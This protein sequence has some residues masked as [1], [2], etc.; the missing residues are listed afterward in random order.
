MNSIFLQLPEDIQLSILQGAEN[1]LGLRAAIIEKD[2]WVCWLLQQI[3]SL[4]EAMAFKGGTSLSKVF[5]LI[6]RFSEDIDI[7]IDYRNFIDTIDFEHSSKNQFKQLGKKLKDAMFRYVKQTILP[8]LKLRISEAF[9]NK[10]FKIELDDEAENLRFYYPSLLNQHEHY[11][12]EHV[13]IEFGARN[14]THPNAKHEITTLLAKAVDKLELPVTEVTTLSPIRTFWEKTTL[15]HV[16]CHRNRL[17]ESPARLSRHWYDLAMLT[18]SWIGKEALAKRE[19]LA[20]VIRHKKAF[21]NASY[22]HY[23]DCLN[24]RL[25]LIP[26]PEEQKN[27][28]EDYRKMVDSAMF[29]HEPPP[30][31]EIIKVLTD[32][33]KKINKDKN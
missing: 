10:D 28:E 16:E 14:T 29:Q 23:D 15:I 6:D 30:F 22:S 26:N 5:G 4:P 3:F 25:R 24:N 20:D 33:E 31:G 12:R 21:F 19:I 18:N 17:L 27:L 8:F 9:P 2:V 7:T 1:K 11:L 13:L 32:L